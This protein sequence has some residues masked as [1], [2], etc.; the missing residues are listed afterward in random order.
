MSNWFNVDRKGLAALMKGRSKAFILHELIANAWDEATKTVKVTVERLDGG[1]N[2][3]ISVEDDNP[4]GFQDIS[5]AYTLFAESK[6]KSNSE[7]RGRFNLGEKLVLSLAKRAWIYTTTASLVFDDKGRAK[8]VA[9]RNAGSEIRVE[10]PMIKTEM[11]EMVESAKRLIPPPGIITTVNGEDLPSREPA[12]WFETALP[13]LISD[14]EGV[15]RRTER[16][17]LVRV[18]EPLAGENAT[19]YEMGIPVVETGDR[20]HVDVQQKVLLNSDRDNVMPG[21]LRA[22]R[23]AVLNHTA[24]LISKEDTAQTWVGEAI[25]DKRVEDDAVKTV[26]LRRFGE[27]AVAFDPS[28][29]EANKISTAEGRTVV[30]GGSLTGEQWE[31][32]RR[33]G[34]LPPAGQVTPSPKPFHPDGKPL[35]PI[36][37]SEWTAGMHRIANFIRQTHFSLF[38]SGINV[39][40]VDEPDWKFNATY[41]T[42]GFILNKWC[43]A[44]HYFNGDISECVIDLVIHEFGHHIESDH[45]SRKYNDALTKIGAQMTRLA[46]EKPELF[47]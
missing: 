34:A 29:L 23:V 5:H 47:R 11:D 42:G 24:H 37:S 4:D 13:T 32:V 15:L 3:L 9:K 46:L 39:Q 2:T 28:D 38:G 31:N 44:D 19:L 41:G 43:L 21:Y 12:T 40:I 33:A 6:K 14:E 35:R 27:N 7:K 17:T 45:L 30:Y 1:R 36:P 8:H 16:K 26:F 10:I 22:I 20:F 25:S 18:Y